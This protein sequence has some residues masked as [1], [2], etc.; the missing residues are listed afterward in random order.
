MRE[1]FQARK[2]NEI[3]PCV[4]FLEEASVFAP[5]GVLVPSSEILKAIATQARG[6]NFILVSIF[7]RSSM[8]S[9]DVLSQIGNWFIGKT[10][11]PGDRQAI[12]RNAEN[13]ETEHDKVI[14]NLKIAKQFLITG[15][16]VE[17][18]AV[19]EIPDQK[20]LLSKGGRVKPTVIEATFRREDMTEYVAKIR[21]LEETE[22][23]RLKDE[24]ARLRSVRD[25]K[26]KAPVIPKETQKEL[27]RLKTELQQMQA[28]YERALEHL[29]EKEKGA[30]RKASERYLTTIKEQ[31][32]TIERLT[33]QIAIAGAGS[34][35]EK[36]VWEQ[37]IVKHRL[38]ALSE[39]QRDLVVFL[40]RSGPSAAE[41]IAPTLGV[42]PK[43]V[44][45]YVS[46]INA[47]IHGLVAFDER[48]GAYHSRIKEL[49]PVQQ[50]ESS[51]EHERTLAEVAQLQQELQHARETAAA[52]TAEASKLQ[53]EKDQLVKQLGSEKGED[54]WA[55]ILK[56]LD[57]RLGRLADVVESSEK[58]EE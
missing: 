38:N 15:F 25:E 17:T 19:A 41:K 29:K 20:I 11:N 37:E 22:Q 13:I 42:A 49:F 23:K 55:P 4:V 58:V 33:R 9:K 54:E 2:N 35:E 39:K 48:K 26:L 43:T 6:Y 8:T 50:G 36:P 45:V 44:T 53:Q 1:L 27:D 30:D 21:S 34:S 32:A 12:L 14:K 46:Q 47:K 57:S 51:K 10:G 3:G 52:K 28:R 24:I 40:E 18:P 16:V 5:E 31:Q 7:Q 56:E